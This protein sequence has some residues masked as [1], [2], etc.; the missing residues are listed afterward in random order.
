M[1][2][3]S[4]KCV[5]ILYKDYYTKYR[6]IDRDKIESILKAAEAE[7][8]DITIA[9]LHWGSEYNDTV[10]ETQ[11]DIVYIMQKAGVD[12]IIGSHPHRVQHI[13]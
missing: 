6:E 8:P 13:T 1:P 9:L 7:K 2:A 5:N 3:G 10:Y 4:E 11:E 12:V